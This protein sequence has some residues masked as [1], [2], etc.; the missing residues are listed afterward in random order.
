MKQQHPSESAI[1]TV[2]RTEEDFFSK[3]GPVP[4]SFDDMRRFPRFYYRMQV[5]ATIYPLPGIEGA[6][7]TPCTLLTRDL[8]RGGVNVLHTEQLFPAQRIDLVLPDGVRRS[9]EVVWC[10]R[11]APRCWWAGCRFIR[12]DRENSDAD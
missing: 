10:R 7:P 12:P 4:A 3:C 6:I 9:V 1:P 2:A 11:L 5:S 8:S